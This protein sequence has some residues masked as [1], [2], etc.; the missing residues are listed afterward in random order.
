MRPR[1][2]MQS[3]WRGLGVVTG[4]KENRCKEGPCSVH[5]SEKEW[6]TFMVHIC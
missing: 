2:G 5:D 4:A 1:E 6:R 3:R